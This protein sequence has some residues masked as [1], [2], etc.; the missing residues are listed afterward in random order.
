MCL[1]NTVP[2]DAGVSPVYL[3]HAASFGSVAAG[4]KKSICWVLFHRRLAGSLLGTLVLD[5]QNENA[6]LF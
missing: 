5:G 4:G 6:I 3:A 2:S 1:P